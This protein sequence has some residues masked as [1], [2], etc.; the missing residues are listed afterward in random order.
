[1]PHFENLRHINK[2]N[3]VKKMNRYITIIA[4][5]AGITTTCFSQQSGWVDI[6]NNLPDSTG[7]ASLSDMYW[8]N[9]TVGWICSSFKGEIYHTTDGGNTFTTQTTQYYTNAIWMLNASE[10]YAGGK[11]GRVYHTTDNGVTWN[12]IGSIGGT[13]SSISFPPSSDTGY[14]SGDNGKIYSITSSGVSAMASGVITGLRSISFPSSSFGWTCGSSLILYFNGNW[15]QQ[16][17]PAD[18]YNGIFMLNE[19]TGWAVGA[20]GVIVKTENGGQSGQWNYQT[21]PD[22]SKKALN[23][24]FF[25]NANEGWTVGNSGVI[26]HTTNGGTNWNIEAAGTTTNMLRAVQFTS[27]T[28]G[29]VL[30]NNGT[31]LHYTSHSTGVSEVIKDEDMILLPNPTNGIVRFNLQGNVTIKRIDVFDMQ[32]KQVL[33]IDKASDNYIDLSGLGNGIYLLQL[34]TPDKIYKQKIIKE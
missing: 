33:H 20:L 1:M 5:L 2:Y 15:S 22:A 21:N 17:P 14:C 25:L 26:L 29:Y 7:I 16:D 30:G 8:I 32:G 28:N 31:L 3:N 27:P 18:S 9:D 23:D 13:L 10:G 34:E 6:S 12:V 11:E 4:F 19:T 24:V